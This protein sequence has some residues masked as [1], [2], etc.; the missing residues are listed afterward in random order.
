M[1][2]TWVPRAP[3]Q[4][5]IEMQ[6]Q[7]RPKRCKAADNSRNVPRLQKDSFIHFIALPSFG[8]PLHTADFW[9]EFSYSID[10]FYYA[11]SS[12][13]IFLRAAN[14]VFALLCILIGIIGTIGTK[15]ADCTIHAKHKIRSLCFVLICRFIPHWFACLLSNNCNSMDCERP[16][17]DVQ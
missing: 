9:W 2:K 13:S 5:K 6:R 7:L 14:F 11:F 12:K 4:L 3:R 8:T 1:Y 17:I 10:V 15:T 16:T